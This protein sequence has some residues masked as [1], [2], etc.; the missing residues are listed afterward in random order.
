VRASG[1]YVIAV[2]VPM[3]FVTLTSFLVYFIGAAFVSGRANILLVCLIAFVGT[4]FAVKGNLP[5]G[6]LRHRRRPLGKV[7][8]RAFAIT[9]GVLL[10]A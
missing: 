1:Y 5:A 6:L 10:L 9:A 2:I 4:Q 7:D 8:A 3:L